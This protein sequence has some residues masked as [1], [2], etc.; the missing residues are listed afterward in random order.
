M[1]AANR[2]LWNWAVQHNHVLHVGSGRSALGRVA[3]IFALSGRNGAGVAPFA[4][5]VPVDS[6]RVRSPSNFFSGNFHVISASIVHGA[7]L[8]RAC[9]P[10]WRSSHG[11]NVAYLQVQ[12]HPNCSSN[13]H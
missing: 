12:L 9:I 6:W 2:G 1:A 7:K 3:G 11:G 10:R 5:V 8:D 4:A 13:P